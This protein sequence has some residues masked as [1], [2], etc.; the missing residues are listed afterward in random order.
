LQDAAPGN[1]ALSTVDAALAAMEREAA[2]ALSEEAIREQ[3]VRKGWGE[4]VAILRRAATPESGDAERLPVLCKLLGVD[5]AQLL[6]DTETVQRAAQ[7][8]ATRSRISE[9]DEARLAA[10]RKLRETED[11]HEKEIW[12]AH[13]EKDAAHNRYADAMYG[14][15]ERLTIAMRRR[16]QL[17]AP[18]EQ[19][20]CPHLLV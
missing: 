12:T 13:K 6:A 1:E 17:F 20:V 19:P 16:P 14:T 9:L 2:R 8:L 10:A 7:D 15:A 18:N 4:Y 5:S 11:R 3:A